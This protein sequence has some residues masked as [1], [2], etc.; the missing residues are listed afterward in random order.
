[1]DAVSCEGSRLIR[2]IG[3][4]TWKDSVESAGSGCCEL[5]IL[6]HEV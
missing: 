6:G 1:M 2:P 5:E 3:Y 4:C